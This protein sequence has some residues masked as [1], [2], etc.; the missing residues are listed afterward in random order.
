M[1]DGANRPY[2]HVVDWGVS[3]NLGMRSVL[4]SLELMEALQ[5]VGLPT[6]LDHVRRVIVFVVNSLSSPKTDWD[7]SMSAPGAIPIMLKATGVP[8]DHYSFEAVELLKDKQAKW[9]KHEP[10][11]AIPAFARRHGSGRQEALR[12]PETTIYAI[13]VSFAQ[14]TDDAERAYMNELPTSF[15][16]PPG[17]WTACALQPGGSSWRHPSSSRLLRGLGGSIEVA[18]L[19]DV[20]KPAEVASPRGK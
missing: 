15:S 12:T 18:P 19:Q 13:D 20:G 2:I 6:R 1:R 5:S 8:I 14:L 4:D 9:Q 17:P 16:L 7:K 11:P 3:D 10:A